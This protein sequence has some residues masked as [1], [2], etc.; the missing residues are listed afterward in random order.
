MVA[1]YVVVEFKIYMSCREFFPESWKNIRPV[2]SLSF[3]HGRD[4]VCF[5]KPPFLNRQ[6]NLNRSSSLPSL[7]HG[8]G[9]EETPIFVLENIE[10]YYLLDSY[11][12]WSSY[13]FPLKKVLNICF[14]F[15]TTDNL[16]VGC[17]EAEAGCG[18]NGGRSQGK[19]KISN[20]W[21][22][23]FDV[24]RLLIHSHWRE[25]YK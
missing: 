25:T 4:G 6:G 19:K 5:S 7:D 8:F 15:Q 18:S 11:L 14:L 3:L 9:T 10:Q 16:Q 2:I 23:V 20:M 1:E 13:T 22:T 24:R 12:L 17:S 21:S